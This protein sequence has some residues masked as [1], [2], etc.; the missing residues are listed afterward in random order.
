M[1]KVIYIIVLLIFVSAVSN[2]KSTC[3]ASFTFQAT[4]L[5]VSFTDASTSTNAI[6]SWQWDFGDGN[7]SASQNPSHTYA[8]ADTY[9]VCLT[10]HDNHGCS[11]TFCHHVTVT[12]AHPCHASFTFGTDSTG[13]IVHFTNT[14]TGTT[15]STTYSWDFGDGG[16]ST[17]ENPTYTYTHTGHHVVCLYIDDTTTGCSSHF[18][19][20]VFHG[21][22]HHQHAAFSSAREIGFDGDDYDLT[23]YPNPVSTFTLVEYQLNEDALVKIEFYDLLGNKLIEQTEME[24]AG[25]KIHELVLSNFSEGVYIL[26]VSSGENTTVTKKISIQH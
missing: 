24:T 5:S 4:G 6:S 12:S 21:H 8:V 19:H 18:C 14:S 10:I 1:K 2:A 22:V 13:T 11:S 20:V 26:R 7:T 3:N 25:K 16:T 15:G 17:L 23:V 9:Y